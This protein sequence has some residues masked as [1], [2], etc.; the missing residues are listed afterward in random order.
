MSM[1]Y[2]PQVCHVT[3]LHPLHYL[4]AP[5]LH[6]P[7]STLMYCATPGQRTG[8]ASSS[9]VMASAV[10]AQ[11]QHPQA[12]LAELFTSASRASRH[13]ASAVLSAT[14]HPLYCLYLREMG[15][16]HDSVSN[17]RCG[18]VVGVTAAS[19]GCAGHPLLH[20][21]QTSCRINIWIKTL[22]S[23][24]HIHPHQK[25]LS[26]HVTTGTGQ[27]NVQIGS[28]DQALRCRAAAP[29]TTRHLVN[30][31]CCSCALS[32]LFLVGLFALLARVS[33]GQ[34]WCCWYGAGDCTFVSNCSQS[35]P[36]LSLPVQ[37][38]SWCTAEMLASDLPAP[39]PN[40][41]P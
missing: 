36:L 17:S 29:L 8:E 2:T 13:P 24:W 11:L 22:A 33:A 3:D 9:E 23:L 6:Q 35:L 10:R 32:A 38:R 1:C 26:L 19:P 15:V 40:R 41:A 27:K 30:M 21:A 14:L 39:W 16:F 28:A 18:I 25:Q 12:E 37:M 31:P 34:L 7:S 4:F 20:R 5:C